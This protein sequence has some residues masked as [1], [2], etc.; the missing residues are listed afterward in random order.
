LGNALPVEWIANDSK[1]FLTWALSFCIMK[2]KN[3]FGCFPWFV[4]EGCGFQPFRGYWDN[5]S[6]G[7]KK[8]KPIL[9][10]L[11]ADGAYHPSPAKR[12]PLFVGVLK[13]GFQRV[14]L[15]PQIQ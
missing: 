3:R 5:D 11:M 4:Q 8:S 12:N 2:L 9:K 10:E 15:P 6:S 13:P 1:Q 7:A 14:F